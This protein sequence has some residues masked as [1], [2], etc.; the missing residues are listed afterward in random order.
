MLDAYDFF[1][2]YLTFSFG[3]KCNVNF[4]KTRNNHQRLLLAQR[5]I[6]S[7]ITGM[8]RETHDLSNTYVRLA[9]LLGVA[10]DTGSQKRHYRQEYRQ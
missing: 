7:T 9:P 10:H 8:A 1:V 4:S 3:S 2:K 5:I 6:T